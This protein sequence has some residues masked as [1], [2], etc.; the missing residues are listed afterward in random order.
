M[1]EKEKF[2]VR[3]LQFKR[4][5]ARLGYVI[6]MAAITCCFFGTGFY[7]LLEAPAGTIVYSILG[8]MLLFVAGI[9]ILGTIGVLKGINR[10]DLDN[11][12]TRYSNPQR[13]F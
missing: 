1:S 3:W 12:E 10:K 13:R 8:I 6:K 9:L 4:K 11:M 7:M 5:F 2:S